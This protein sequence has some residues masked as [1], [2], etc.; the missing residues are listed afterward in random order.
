MNYLAVDVRFSEL[1]IPLDPS[2]QLPS[3]GLPWWAYVILSMFITSRDS[4]ITTTM[5]E[6]T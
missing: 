4:K 5:E 6:T 2:L 3:F 1:W